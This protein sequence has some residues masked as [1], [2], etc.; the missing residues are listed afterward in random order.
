MECEDVRIFLS[1]VA[2]GVIEYD[3]D[4]HSRLLSTVRV[5]Q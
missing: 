2:F 1:Q 5:L 3:L 4:Q